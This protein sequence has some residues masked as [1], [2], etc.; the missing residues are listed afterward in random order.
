MKPQ[1]IGMH[2]RGYCFIVDLDDVQF[3]CIVSSMHSFPPA[4]YCTLVL[5]ERDS[6]N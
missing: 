3:S 4:A 2:E 5:L 1:E 6:E